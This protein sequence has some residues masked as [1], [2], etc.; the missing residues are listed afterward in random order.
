MNMSDFAY[1]YAEYLEQEGADDTPSSR[2][3]FAS[4]VLQSMETMPN[5]DRVQHAIEMLHVI[6]LA[7]RALRELLQQYSDVLKHN[8]VTMENMVQVQNLINEYFL[9][10]REEKRNDSV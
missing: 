6:V 4:V 1:D 3:I 10:V 7:N 5:P 8:P 2:F 9:T